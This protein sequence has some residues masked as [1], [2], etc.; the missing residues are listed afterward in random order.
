MR[1]PFLA[2][3]D[4]R[5]P[6]A[7]CLRS[8]GSCCK[9]K[10]PTWDRE[11]SERCRCNAVLCLYLVIDVWQ[12]EC[13]QALFKEWESE[14]RFSNGFARNFLKQ[15]LFKRQKYNFS[16]F[17]ISFFQLF[18][19]V[20]SNYLVWKNLWEPIDNP[21]TPWHCFF[22]SAHC[23]LSRYHKVM[24][25]KWCIKNITSGGW[26]KIHHAYKHMIWLIINV[27]ECSPLEVGSSADKKEKYWFSKCISNQ[28]TWR[29]VKIHRTTIW[30]HFR[31]IVEQISIDLGE[32]VVRWYFL[33]CYLLRG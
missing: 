17:S 30:T 27:H 3:Q 5:K 21:D 8:W 2:T 33:R 1:K 14:R 29:K 15:T 24:F 16:C 22:K 19:W 26:Y 6:L 18:L 23:S 9:W 32:K 4:V 13:R 12:A 20:C 10:A 31:N 28:S 11:I 25:G 7:L